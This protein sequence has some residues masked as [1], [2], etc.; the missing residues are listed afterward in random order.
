[1]DRQ[2]DIDKYRVDSESDGQIDRQMDRHI[3]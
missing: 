3:G 1:M 2:M